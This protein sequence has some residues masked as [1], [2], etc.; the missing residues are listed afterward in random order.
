MANDDERSRSDGVILAS[1]ETPTLTKAELAELLFDRL[2]LNKRESKDMVEAFFDIVHDTLVEGKGRQT[3]R[4]WQLQHQA[5]GASARAKSANRRVDPDQGTQR[6]DLPR[7]SQAEIDRARRHAAGRRL[8]VESSFSSLI[9]LISMEKALPSIPAKRY[10]TIG[11]VS[12]LCGVKPYVLRYWEQEFTQLKPMKRRGNRRYYQHHEVLAGPSYPRPALR[13][14]IH[15]QWGPQSPVRCG[16]VRCPRTSMP[17]L[18][19]TMPPEEIPSRRS[20]SLT[21]SPCLC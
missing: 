17:R 8:R 18:L 20:R 10:F 7:E 3:V 14:G 5:Q 13:P 1:L 6:R 21:L 12:E 9:P 11:E 19:W 16:H 4:V 2:G 15:D